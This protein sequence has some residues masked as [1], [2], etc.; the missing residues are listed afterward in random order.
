[1]QFPTFLLIRPTVSKS[2]TPNHSITLTSHPT[3]EAGKKV[4]YIHIHIPIPIHP[5]HTTSPPTLI[6]SSSSSQQEEEKVK[7]HQR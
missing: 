5:S 4:G 3:K 6:S 1:M 2:H 7:L